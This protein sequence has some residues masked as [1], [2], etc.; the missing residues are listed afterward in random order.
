MRSR[1][2]VLPQ[3]TYVV[4]FASLPPMSLNGHTDTGP[5]VRRGSVP[6]RHRRRERPPGVR[7][8]VRG[9]RPRFNDPAAAPPC[10]SSQQLGPRVSSPRGL[11]PSPARKQVHRSSR[12]DAATRVGSRN[13][14]M[15]GVHV[16]HDCEA[17]HGGAAPARLSP[18]PP[19]RPGRTPWVGSAASSLASLFVEGKA[20]RIPRLRGR[21]STA[22]RL[23]HR[24]ADWR[25]RCHLKRSHAGGP[26][27]RRQP[28][29]HRR[30]RP[31]RLG[32]LFSLVPAWVTLCNSE[33]AAT[34][35]PGSPRRRRGG[36]AARRGGPL[37]L[38]RRRR[39]GRGERPRL[40]P[41]QGGPRAPRGGERRGPAAR[42]VQPG[43]DPGASSRHERPH[44]AHRRAELSPAAGWESVRA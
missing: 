27:P 41:R 30:C 7:P 33:G 14:I 2:P 29:R 22:P 23:T 28:R 39:D 12:E 24:R 19:L 34:A 5:Q 26:R 38:R 3:P 6:P 20:R 43:G 8:G 37:R 40:P 16:A 31:C 9:P 13:L 17:R 11:L 36:A 44:P 42:R 32:T 21:V 1:A 4:R 25:Q 15:G 18:L 35:P 10:R